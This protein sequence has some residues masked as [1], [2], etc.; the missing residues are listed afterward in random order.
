MANQKPLDF[1][2]HQIKAASKVYKK[3]FYITYEL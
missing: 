3:K 2:Q 1:Y